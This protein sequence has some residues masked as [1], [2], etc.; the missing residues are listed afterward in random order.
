MP[1]IEGGQHENLKR[2][3]R[4]FKRQKKAR[5]TPATVAPLILQRQGP[6]SHLEENTNFCGQCFKKVYQAGK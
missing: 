3:A 4:R 1:T 2:G 6:V 5:N